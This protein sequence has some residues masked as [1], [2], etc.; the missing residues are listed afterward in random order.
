MRHSVIFL[1]EKSSDSRR[2]CLRELIT[3]LP[4]TCYSR[5]IE[6]THTHTGALKGYIFKILS[7]VIFYLALPVGAVRQRS[8]SD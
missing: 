4:L 2:L 6:G 1:P 8:Y 7:L 5:S 3:C